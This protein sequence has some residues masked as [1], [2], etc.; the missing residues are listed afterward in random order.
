MELKSTVFF[1]TIFDLILERQCIF[2]VDNLAQTERT[3]DFICRNS[4]L[5]RSNKNFSNSFNGPKAMGLLSVA[6]YNILKTAIKCC[7]PL[8]P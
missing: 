1:F 4:G 2:C 8:K 6:I 7:L 3:N 5:D